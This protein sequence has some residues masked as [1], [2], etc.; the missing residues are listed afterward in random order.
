MASTAAATPYRPPHAPAAGCFLVCYRSL[1]E[2]WTLGHSWR[3]VSRPKRLA[4]CHKTSRSA[5]S[6]PPEEPAVSDL[7]R[8]LGHFLTWSFCRTTSGA[9]FLRS[10]PLA[11]ARGNWR[12][13]PGRWTNSW[14]TAGSKTNPSQTTSTLRLLEVWNSSGLSGPSR[15][16]QTGEVYLSADRTT[17]KLADAADEI[18]R[19][20]A[21]LRPLSLAVPELRILMHPEDEGRTPKGASMRCWH[22]RCGHDWTDPVFY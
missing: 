1:A 8:D 22:A 11:S 10:P 7:S 6:S 3:A 9:L 19:M 4:S 17:L 14:S 5:A 21:I 2:A 13:G 15:H 18:A 12:H 20:D 16:Y